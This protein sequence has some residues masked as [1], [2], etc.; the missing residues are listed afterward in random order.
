MGAVAIMIIKAIILDWA[1]TTVDYGSRAPTLAFREV[2]KREGVPIKDLEARTPMGKAKRE[3]IAAIAAMPRVARS[4][5]RKRG[6]VIGKADIDR[7]YERF[8]PIQKELLLTHSDVIPGVVEAIRQCREWG[9]KIGSTT[10]YSR[11]LMEVVAPIAAAQGYSPDVIVC[12]DD[13]AKGRPSPQMNLRAAELLGVPPSSE[14][15]V[16]DD[17]TVGCEAGERAGCIA[18]G[19]S[20]TG[21]MLGM[22][23]QEIEAEDPEEMEDALID[24][25]W[26][27]REA[28]ARFVIPAVADLPD[29]IQQLEDDYQWRNR[30]RLPAE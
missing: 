19:V 16:L 3:H 8:L 12:A 4:W 14:V 10:G 5:K 15:L 21:N 24:V 7:M 9:I 26:P 18:V 27:L 17:T 11:E 25:D 28:G 23:L 22:T 29:L 6:S 1:G 13:V 20:K 30:H 2:F